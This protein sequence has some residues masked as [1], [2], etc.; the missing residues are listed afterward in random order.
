LSAENGYGPAEERPTTKA[1]LTD[2]FA[3][4]YGL[5]HL[6][7]LKEAERASKSLDAGIADNDDGSYFHS[8]V[9]KSRMELSAE[10]FLLEA[11]SRGREAKTS[12]L[13]QVYGLGLGVWMWQ[14]DV[15]RRI[16]LQAFG[17]V[18]KRNNFEW[19]TVVDFRLVLQ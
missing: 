13:A 16:F 4:F 15:Q 19:V 9:Y 6:P 2:L 7:T 12:I 18:I 8:A 17:N 5:S 10:T 1:H 11:E 3:Q 14:P